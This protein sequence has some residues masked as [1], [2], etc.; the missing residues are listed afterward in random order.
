MA[1]LQNLKPPVSRTIHYPKFLL[2]EFDFEN[3]IISLLIH[4]FEK[5]PN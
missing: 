5:G 1:L 3:K 4:I 2:Q